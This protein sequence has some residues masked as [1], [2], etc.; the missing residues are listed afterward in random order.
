MHHDFHLITCSR[1]ITILYQDENIACKTKKCFDPLVPIPLSNHQEIT[2]RPERRGEKNDW[3]E[4]EE[5]KKEPN[6]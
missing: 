2:T 5:K 4:E 6:F 1:V 3:K